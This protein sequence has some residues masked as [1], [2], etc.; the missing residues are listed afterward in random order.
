MAEFNLVGSPEPFLHVSMKQ[1]EAIYC[2]SDA[3]VMVEQNLEVGGKLRGEFF[4]HLCVNSLLE[5]LC[6]N[7][8]LKP[9]KGQESVYYHRI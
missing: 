8:K 5:S 7:S 2:E 3:M 9:L 4:K 1:G 6:F